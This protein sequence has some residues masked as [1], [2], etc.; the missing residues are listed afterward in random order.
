M[1][2]LTKLAFF[3]LTLLIGIH[4][5]ALVTSAIGYFSVPSEIEVADPNEGKPIFATAPDG[6]Q[7]SYIGR[8]SSADS[9]SDL[10]FLI[11]NGSGERLSCIG[12]SGRCVA[13]EIRIGTTDANAWVCLNGTSTYVIEPGSSAEL[14]VGPYG[15]AR[16]P[17]RSE[18]V[19]VGY[20]FKYSDGRKERYFAEPIA[21]PDEFRNLLRKELKERE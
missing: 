4:T 17:G 12:Y 5:T 8:S 3:L 6:I 9:G 10:R 19:E 1:R 15:F 18:L 14:E 20:E 7:I 21:I 13:P 11:Y 16:L 2:T